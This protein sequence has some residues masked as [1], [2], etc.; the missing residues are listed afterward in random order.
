MKKGDLAAAIR[1]IA[2]SL[3][4]AATAL[5]LAPEKVNVR[6]WLAKVLAN[7]PYDVASLTFEESKIL[8]IRKKIWGRTLSAISSNFLEL[9]CAD[10]REELRNFAKY[11]FQATDEVEAASK[12]ALKES[13][14]A[15]APM[16]E[17]VADFR[18]R[19]KHYRL[20]V[21]QTL[22][23]NYLQEAREEAIAM[24]SDSE[25]MDLGPDDPRLFG[26]VS[27]REACEYVGCKSGNSLRQLE[28]ATRQSLL[29]KKIPLTIFRPGRYFILLKPT[30]RPNST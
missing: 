27:E 13:E 5:D 21:K 4:A 11:A 15:T 18:Y 10:A 3:D 2:L 6:E 25:H 22:L 23:L 19:G 26:A 8:P 29:R 28:W 17:L 1:C 24:K 7:L 9:S 30:S 20:P 14:K 16:P 12:K